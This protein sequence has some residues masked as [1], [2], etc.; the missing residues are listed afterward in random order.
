LTLSK[1]LEQAATGYPALRA[2]EAG[3]RS[4]TAHI[5]LARTAYLP[6]VDGIVGF[7]RASR[8]NVFG[9]LLPSQVIAPIPGPVLQ[10]NDAA[11]AWGSTV[12]V[13]VTW[14]PFDFGLRAASVALAAAGQK[15]AEAEL[16]AQRM[17][18]SIAVAD[19]FLT[20]LAA[21]QMEA[22]AKAAV[23]RAAELSRITE[24]LTQA[25]LRP[26]IDA[27]LA[28]AEQA[29]AAA[30]L[31]QAQQAVAESRASLAGLVGAE[32][33]SLDLVS[34][35]LLKA[36][37]PLPDGA[38]LESNPAVR[39]KDTQIAES[40]LR[41]EAINKSFVPRFAVQGTSFARGSGAN[42]DGTLGGGLS[43]LGPNIHNWALGMTATWPLADL[44]AIRA[45]RQAEIAGRDAE[46]GR[47]DQLLLDLQIRR[48]RAIAAH[49]SALRMAEIAPV[50]VTAARAALAQATARYQAGL[51]SAVEVTET[52]RR[53]TQAEIDERLAT[54]A[55]WRARLSFYAAQGDLT[56]LAAEAN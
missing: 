48:Q 18:L 9:L 32:A 56:P 29:A 15:R 47:R 31:V 4:A 55:I 19:A 51:I 14:E 54:L 52:Q 35:R 13:L 38:P 42:L 34:G 3:I 1:A 25:E 43:G 26:G 7:N 44:A 21:E 33:Q 46:R 12:G 41:L 50:A 8:N 10:T 24:A 37:A 27:T 22:G 6:K 23:A 2:A 30:Q 17:E 11:S 49:A 5:A 53:L 28:R 40:G 36:P 45:R 16:S 20:V 39:H